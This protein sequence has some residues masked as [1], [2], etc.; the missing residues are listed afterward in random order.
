MLG[1]VHCSVTACLSSSESRSRVCAAFLGDSLNGQ[2]MAST[3]LP[4]LMLLLAAIV[5]SADAIKCVQCDNCGNSWTAPS[6]SEC[7]K[8]TF[9][10]GVND[11][12]DSMNLGS[13]ASGLESLLNKASAAV[14][15]SCYK[16][17]AKS[18]SAE[19]VYR[20]CSPFSPNEDP[21]CSTQ[22]DRETCTYICDGD[23]CNSAPTT[24]MSGTI[25]MTCLLIAFAFILA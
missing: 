6:S 14:V 25:V 17:V 13:L 18:G 11:F 10:E 3:V 9:P 2:A 5:S 22:G 15:R 24:Y 23:G 16:V 12:F 1:A 8:V 21:S 20:G 7:T 19:T 4:M